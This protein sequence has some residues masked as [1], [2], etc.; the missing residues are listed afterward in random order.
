MQVIIDADSAPNIKDLEIIFRKY[1][2]K[3]T[4]VC[5]YN[6]NL[7]SDYS[8]VINVSKGANAADLYILNHLN[9]GDM[10]IT[11]DLGLSVGA[12]SKNC[13]VID[14]KGNIINNDNIDFS[15]EI[16]HMSSLYRKH[17][18]YLKGHKK[19]TLQ[20]KMNLLNKVEDIIKE[21]I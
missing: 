7:V 8:N 5:D 20:D 11:N 19:R 21:Y 14:S 9:E 13:L 12:L 15:L 1:N 17:N 10:L 4:L 16:R 6:H 3:C 2:I 18:K